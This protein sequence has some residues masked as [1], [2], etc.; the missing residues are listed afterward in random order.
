MQKQERFKTYALLEITRNILWLIVGILIV[1]DYKQGNFVYIL[2]SHA[3]LSLL[4]FII[5]IKKVPSQIGSI[6]KSFTYLNNKKSLISYSVLAGL[7]PY[8]VFIA[9]DKFGSNYDISALGAALRYQAIL[10]L[11]VL[12]INTVVLSQIGNVSILKNYVKNLWKKVYLA[13]T[14]CLL[15]ILCVYFLIPFIDGGKY[16]DSKNYFLL[17]SA[18]TILSLF[19]LPPVSI[20][21]KKMQYGKILKSLLVSLTVTATLVFALYYFLGIEALQS[22]E[23]LLFSMIFAYM[24]NLMINVWQCLRLQYEDIDC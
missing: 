3:I 2:Y 7:F 13:V 17:L 16:P 19:N 8:I 22:I 23:I 11:V 15:F 18:T 1:Y 5:G 6:S 12:S 20:L 21:L 10:S 4:I 9:T 24:I 14:I